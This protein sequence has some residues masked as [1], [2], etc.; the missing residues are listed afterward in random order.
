MRS[1]GRKPSLVTDLPRSLD[2]VTCLPVSI[3]GHTTRTTIKPTMSLSTPSRSPLDGVPVS[4]RSRHDSVNG[5][6]GREFP[7]A[8][9]SWVKTAVAASLAA[10]AVGVAVLVLTGMRDRAIYSKPVDEL[11]AHRSKYVG[12][13]LRAEGDLVHGSLMKRD[14][15]CEYRF[16]L[17]RHD[18]ALSVR[19][20]G[21]VVP[22]TFR[23]VADI[24]LAVTVEGELQEDG[25][26]EANNVLAKCPS[27]YEM[28]QRKD[29]GEAL[30]H[31]PLAAQTP[32]DDARRPP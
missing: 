13:P 31:P 22:D 16:S 11:M 24:D 1:F 26:F 29:R 20:L 15:P 6:F 3:D 28:Q 23:D 12:H 8:S 4:S 30:P 17:Q 21:C 5:R 7:N 18:V 2:A 32:T 25:I 14:K 10:G 9:R 27:K 19:Y